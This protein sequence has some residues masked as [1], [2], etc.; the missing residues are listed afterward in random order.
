MITW[1]DSARVTL[2]SHIQ[3][4]RQQLLASGA[5]PDEVAADLHR[6]IE[7]ELIA[8][9]IHVATREDVQRVLARIGATV[10]EVPI[11]PHQPKAIWPKALLIC[12][13]LAAV[14]AV[15][16]LFL[17][18]LRKKSGPP[19]TTKQVEAQFPYVIDFVTYSPEWGQFSPG[20]EIVITA[21]RSDR[22][23]IEPGGR[24]L[25]EGTYILASMERAVLG[26]SVT[27]PSRDSPGAIGPVYPEQRTEIARSTGGFSLSETM[28]YPGA[29]HVSFNPIGGGESRGTIY[30]R[31]A[32][33]S[34]AKTQ[35]PKR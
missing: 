22:N 7:E 34:S 29:F 16:L 1:T 20:D 33:P 17:P 24:Y 28:L 31:E 32:T 9:K 3:S 27:A 5:D 21:V 13:V 19:I 23:H 18:M 35:E 8:A 12:F 11:P 2:D 6:H 4:V 30:F 10:T 25:V 14:M 15:F 26:L